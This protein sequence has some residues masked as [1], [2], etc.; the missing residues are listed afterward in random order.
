LCS[1]DEYSAESFFGGNV[2][3]SCPEYCHKGGERAFRALNETIANLITQTAGLSQMNID[4]FNLGYY[5]RNEPYTLNAACPDTCRPDRLDTQSRTHGTVNP[6]LL[7]HLAAGRMWWN[8]QGHANESVLT[9]EDLYLDR[10]FT[11][12][13]E[14]LTNDGKPF[15]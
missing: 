12:D 13:K 2:G 9:H 6:I 14:N 1:D 11:D 8:F 10:G 3:S 4:A 5:L 7:G 15:L